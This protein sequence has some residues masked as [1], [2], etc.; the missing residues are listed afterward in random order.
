MPSEGHSPSLIVSVCPGREEEMPW[1]CIYHCRLSCVLR[2]YAHLCDHSHECKITNLCFP[3]FHGLLSILATFSGHWTLSL[4]PPKKNPKCPLSVLQPGQDFHFSNWTSYSVITC[5]LIIDP[6]SSS[7][8]PCR[9]PQ[10]FLRISCWTLASFYPAFC[11]STPE[12]LSSKEKIK[13]PQ[14]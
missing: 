14:N 2:D 4:P 8:S 6:P 13:W 7:H 11:S 3:H 12:I 10:S 5:S 9:Y 1:V